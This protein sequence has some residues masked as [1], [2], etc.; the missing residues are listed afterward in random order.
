[1]KI[2]VSLFSIFLMLNISHSA[3]SQPP[4]P[5]NESTGEAEYIDVIPVDGVKASELYERIDHWYNNFFVNPHSVIQERDEEGNTIHGRHN[6]T[7]YNEVDGVQVRFGQIR[8]NINVMARDGRYRYEINDI[9]VVQR[10]RTP[11]HELLDP[12]SPHKNRNF[13]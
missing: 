1:M 7:V 13:N 8:Y 10:P 3:I 5:L 4:I 11:I 6:M 12:D 9:I 2:L